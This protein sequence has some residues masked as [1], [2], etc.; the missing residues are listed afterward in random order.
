MKTRRLPQESIVLD[1]FE[2]LQEIIWNKISSGVKRFIKT[3]I[4][5]LLE[6]E[7][8]TEPGAGRYERNTKRKA[9]RNGH[10]ERGLLTKFGLI[11]GIRVPR[12]DK[13][14]IEFTVFERYERRRR[15]VDAAIGQLFL[16][17]RST[18]KLKGIAKELYGKEI[19]AQTV[20]NSFSHVDHKLE[21]FKGKAIEDT[22]EF[23]FLDGISQKV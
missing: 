20:S 1:V 22:V 4:E 15:D 17:G 3:F 7:L 2:N 11:E 19:S 6:D 14:G 9:Y 5:N 10:Y 18:R 12:M 13:G 21:R 8:I 16:N 23:L